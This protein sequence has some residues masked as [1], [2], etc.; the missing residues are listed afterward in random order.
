MKA[1]YTPPKGVVQLTYNISLK[2]IKRLELFHQ[3]SKF[4]EVDGWWCPLKVSIE[5][6]CGKQS[7][8]NYKKWIYN[9]TSTHILNFNYKKIHVYMRLEDMTKMYNRKLGIYYKIFASTI[10]KLPK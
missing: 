6:R 10:D 8:S 1:N 7:D 3:R 9:L 2:E 4:K 5:V